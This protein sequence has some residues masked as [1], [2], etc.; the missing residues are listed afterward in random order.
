MPNGVFFRRESSNNFA[1]RIDDICVYYKDA[2]SESAGK[3]SSTDSCNHSEL[4]CK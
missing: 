2:I 4:C 3:N 1:G